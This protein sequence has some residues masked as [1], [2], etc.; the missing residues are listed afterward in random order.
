MVTEGPLLAVTSLRV[1]NANLSGGPAVGLNF[2][3]NPQSTKPSGGPA[4]GT[5]PHVSLQST[6]ASGG[7]TPGRE[8]LRLCTP[9]SVSLAVTTHFTQLLTRTTYQ[10]TENM[11][12]TLR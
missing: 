5:D 6:N 10:R 2:H 7:P 3:G 9:V 8:M 4:L 11:N 12:Q 1:L